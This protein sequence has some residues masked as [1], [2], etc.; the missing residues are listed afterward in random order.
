MPDTYVIK[1]GKLYNPATN[2]YAIII[3]RGY[4]SGWSTYCRDDERELSRKRLFSPALA[5]A[6]ICADRRAAKR[7]LLRLDTEFGRHGDLRFREQML[8]DRVNSLCVDFVSAGCMVKVE[9][10]DGRETYKCIPCD[11]MHYVG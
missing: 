3:T 2:E 11:N 1:N 5:K 9:E 7:A 8:E 6:L 4:G 10:Y